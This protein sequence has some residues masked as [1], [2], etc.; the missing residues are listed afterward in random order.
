MTIPREL[1]DQI[2]THVIQFQHLARPSLTQTFDELVAHRSILGAPKLGGWCKTVLYHPE[3]AVANA[4]SLLRVNRQLRA[5]TLEN[6]KR[7]KSCVYVLDVII[8]DEILPLPTWISVPFYTT[9]VE[10]INT[11]FRI[12]GY[13]DKMKEPHGENGDLVSGPY[14]PFGH[15]K[16]FQGGNGAGPA[17]HWQI[18]SILERVIKVGPLGELSGKGAENEHRHVTVKTIDINIET[19]SGI[20]A[21]RFGAPVSGIFRRRNTD[22]EDSVLDP[23]YLADV[24]SRNITD[25][26]VCTNHE[27]FNYAKVL[28]EH[29]DTVVVRLD[30]EA[31]MRL[32]VAEWLEWVDGFQEHHLSKVALGEY[33]AK[34]WKLRRERGLKVPAKEA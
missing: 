32:D 11:T 21:S 10:Q 13:Y 24:I 6:I 2:C 20:D 4:S 14:A 19:P 17:F 30:G 31:S 33:K 8:L 18:Y 15:Y 5:E 23:K 16:G 9:N 3:D 26:L 25:L 34:A 29:V 1:R 28:Y 27:W 7:L 22:I 12:S